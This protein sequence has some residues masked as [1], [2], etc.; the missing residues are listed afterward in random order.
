MFGRLIRRVTRSEQTTALQEALAEQR[1]TSRR[2]SREVESLHRAAITR[3]DGEN[4]SA[5]SLAS[6]VVWIFGGGRSGTTWMANMMRD[7]SGQE[8]WFEPNIGEIFDPYRLR[9]ERRSKGRHFV[10]SEEFRDVWLGNIRSFVLD[11]IKAR[12]PKLEEDSFVMIKE[13]GGS[14]GAKLLAD[15]LPES[16]MILLVRD[17]RDVISSWKDALE[18]GA[19]NYERLASKGQTSSKFDVG[20]RSRIY[21]QILT[22]S[23]S[24]YEGHTSRRSAV[25]YEDL[26]ADTLSEMRR[27]YSEIGVPVDGDE[28]SRVVEAHSWD[29]IPEEKKG[30]GNFYRRGESGGW[31]EDLTTDQASLIE[32]TTAPVM[33]ALGYERSV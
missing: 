4:L 28:L 26:V 8:V 9:I 10:L 7:L 17:P 22:Q 6:R 24:A 19:W 15:A 1:R 14:I 30:R 3:A 5:E 16:R 33:D 13:P 32:R 21:M 23:L 31:R 11:G 20:R 25:K 29:N 27:M 2:L 12:F 18:E